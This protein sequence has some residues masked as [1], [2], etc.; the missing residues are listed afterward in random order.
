MV[1]VLYTTFYVYLLKTTLQILFLSFFDVIFNNDVGTSSG[2]YTNSIK[3]RINGANDA[4]TGN[5]ICGTHWIGTSFQGDYS[6]ALGNQLG[7]SGSFFNYAG[8]NK[9]SSTIMMRITN[10]RLSKNKSLSISGS[11][12]SNNVPYNVI[13]SGLNLSSSRFDGICYIQNGGSNAT[14]TIEVWAI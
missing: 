8:T 1:Y 4:E 12:L 13:G 14:T 10:P 7:G 9:N 5:Y 11:Y 6:P 2:S 3:F